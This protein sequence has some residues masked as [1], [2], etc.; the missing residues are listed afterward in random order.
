[1]GL[2]MR[3]LVLG[4]SFFLAIQ[5]TSADPQAAPKAKAT[6]LPVRNLS[7][8]LCQGERREGRDQA[9]T[10]FQRNDQGDV[11]SDKAGSGILRRPGPRAS[12]ESH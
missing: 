3:I 12:V 10:E 8:A 6:E 2:V 7:P 5:A 1:M 9:A 11:R 4:F